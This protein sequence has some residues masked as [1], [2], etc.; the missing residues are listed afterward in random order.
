MK[1][2]ILTL[3]TVVALVLIMT[4][5]VLS[6]DLDLNIKIRKQLTQMFESYEVFVVEPSVFV[7]ES[8][9]IV[10]IENSKQLYERF[11]ETGKT[12]LNLEW[13]K[14]DYTTYHIDE[15]QKQ[16]HI[17]TAKHSIV[18]HA[19]GEVYLNGLLWDESVEWIQ[20][21]EENFLE[22]ETL[23]GI[24][25]IQG[26]GIELKSIG[27]DENIVFINGNSSYQEVYVDHETLVFN[28]E[29]SLRDYYAN[30]GADSHY[31]NL[32]SIFNKPA[33]LGQINKTSVVVEIIE[34]DILK[35]V[36][37]NGIVG[38][39]SLLDQSGITEIKPEMTDE[40]EPLTLNEPVYLTWEAVYSYNPKTE[41]IQDM[42][43][44]NVLSPTWYE[45]SNESGDVAEK[46]SNDYINWA[47]GNGD[48]IWALVSNAFDI[49]R[50]HAF[51][52]D[53]QARR[54]FIDYMVME[55]KEKGYSGINIDF[56]NVYLEDKDALTNFVNEFRLEAHTNNIILSMD[57][58][59]MG[60]SDTW[61]KCYD[62]YKLGKIV[63]YLIIMTYD[64][65]WGT[66]PISGPV[67]S[68]DWVYRHMVQLSEVV[69]PSKLVLGLSTYTRVWRERPSTNTA[70]VMVTSSSAI[71]M[72]A[73][74]NL[75]EKYDL[76]PIWDDVDK[77]YYATF[78]EEDALVKMWI[79]TPETLAIR[80]EIVNELELG[81]IA[82]WR[83]G[84]ET[85]DVWERLNQV[86]N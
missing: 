50:T 71:G 83:R 67:A 45:L 53:S 70:N 85:Q 11:L 31:Y 6:I 32:R 37:E 18:I 46:V 68:Y 51:L 4:T 57:V 52:H 55:A 36:D 19:S 10:E 13:I 47:N 27:S 72:E 14:S 49:D 40:I 3:I 7:V 12:Y 21:G 82:I 43:G 2:T 63:D 60:G 78:F 33:V 39:I 1:K 69:N 22:Y 25:D 56:E 41:N 23:L 34:G 81:G 64:E 24:P 74:N 28:T 84:F 65:H 35:I 79:E 48:Q 15:L 29:E 61:S 75:I 54:K 5:V 59:V 73:Q 26:F 8:N 20:I 76:T 42:P 62:H 38:Y 86:I 16:V 17:T 9:R 30:Q 58:T 66:S 77:L 44:V 80:A